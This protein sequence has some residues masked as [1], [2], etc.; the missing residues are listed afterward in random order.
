MPLMRL[1]LIEHVRLKKVSGLLTR[2]WGNSIRYELIAELTPYETSKKNIITV[3]SCD[4]RFARDKRPD[5]ISRWYVMRKS[6][7]QEADA[8][9]KKFISDLE[10]EG[11]DVLEIANETKALY[12]DQKKYLAYIFSLRTGRVTKEAEEK[13]LKNKL[14][15][16]SIQQD[17]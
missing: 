4:L 2:K 8:Q 3:F 5:E 11:W 17:V 14:L 13:D 16:V 6:D 1:K 7:R 9:L 10:A 15:D 12:D